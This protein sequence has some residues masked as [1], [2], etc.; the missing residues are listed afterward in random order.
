[1]TSGPNAGL[2]QVRVVLVRPTIA[3]N[4]GATARVMANFGLRELLLIAPAADPFS[5]EA[6]K[7]SARGE[8]MLDAARIVADFGEAVGPCVLV[9]GTSA[10]SAGQFRGTSAGLPWEILPRAV[11]ARRS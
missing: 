2:E 7:L 11:A 6:R 8:W 1:M 4:I 5:E 10:R 3:A 9:V